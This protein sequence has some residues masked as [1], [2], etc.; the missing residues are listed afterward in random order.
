MNKLRQV[1]QDT[2]KA[3]DGLPKQYVYRQAIEALT[4]HRL[5]LVDQASK[6]SAEAQDIEPALVQLE[7]AADQGSVEQLIQVAQDELALIDKMKEWQ[8]C[9]SRLSGL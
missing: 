8:R 2:L 1:Y 7:Q 3:V 6:Q 9:V 4:Q 5:E